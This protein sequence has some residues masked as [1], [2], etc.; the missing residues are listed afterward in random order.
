MKGPLDSGPWLVVW[1]GNTNVLYRPTFY[2]H[3]SSF[4]NSVWDYVPSKILFCRQRGSTVGVRYG[5]KASI[6]WTWVHTIIIKTR[7]LKGHLSEVIDDSPCTTSLH[8]TVATH[9]DFG[10]SWRDAWMRRDGPFKDRTT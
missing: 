8:Q 7:A 2:T 10:A 1:G 4:F 9:H 6:A 3:H 5:R